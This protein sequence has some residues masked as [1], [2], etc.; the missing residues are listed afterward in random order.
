MKQLKKRKV[1]KRV[2]WETIVDFTKIKAGGVDASEILKRLR[3]N[4]SNIPMKPTFIDHI[5]LIVKDVATTEKFYSS[6]LGKPIQLEKEQV[7]YKIGETKLFLGLP[8]GK[9]KTSDKDRNGLNHLAFG[10]RSLKELKECEKIL[11][12]AKIKNSG[13]KID[14]YGK[15]EFIWLDDPNGIRIEFYCRP[16]ELRRKKIK[17]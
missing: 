10:V 16:K 11:K 4:R 17:N 2:I 9:Y 1:K 5:V 8:Y 3:K 13:I 7:A 14:K 15:K 6:F 12:K